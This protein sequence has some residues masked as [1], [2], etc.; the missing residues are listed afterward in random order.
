MKKANASHFFITG[1]QGSPQNQINNLQTWLLLKCIVLAI[2]FF[3]LFRYMRSELDLS[4][5]SK[6]GGRKG[7]NKGKRGS[8]DGERLERQLIP[9]NVLIIELCTLGTADGGL[10]A[11][12][13]WSTTTKTRI[14]QTCF[15]L[16][17]LS[18]CKTNNNTANLFSNAIS[19]KARFTLDATYRK[20][21]K[22][23]S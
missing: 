6:Q 8:R 13:S 5:L 2:Q 9:S 1:P 10:L 16:L 23:D 15:N 17:L 11:S 14:P 19:Q 7:N 3:D 21:I 18:I 20:N 22:S 4:L 12:S